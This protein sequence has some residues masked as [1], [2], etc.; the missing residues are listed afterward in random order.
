MVKLKGLS[1][2]ECYNHAT[3]F[4]EDGLKI[5]TLHLSN[6]IEAKISSGRPKDLDDLENLS[7]L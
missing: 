2:E 3:Y 7:Q 1:F 5:R 6:L 4:E